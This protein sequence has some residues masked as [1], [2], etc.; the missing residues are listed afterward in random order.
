MPPAFL[1]IG[2]SAKLV[3]DEAVADAFEW[4]AS[5]VAAVHRAF[6][7]RATFWVVDNAFNGGGVRWDD[8]MQLLESTPKKRQ[9]R[10]GMLDEA[11]WCVVADGAAHDK[12]RSQT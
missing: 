2:P 12:A 10:N 3:Q 11:M 4:K 8:T 6:V 7:L 5:R 9:G 1:G